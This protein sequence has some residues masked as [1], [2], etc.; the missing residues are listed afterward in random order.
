MK[1]TREIRIH[2]E[3]MQRCEVQA[4]FKLDWDLFR[5]IPI[6]FIQ[7]FELVH[8]FLLPSDVIMNG[9]SARKH[10]STESDHS[11]SRDFYDKSEV[12]EKIKS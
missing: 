12:L 4:L 5:V 10:I 11:T 7:T 9:E 2:Y 8:G 6:D 1:K 3:D